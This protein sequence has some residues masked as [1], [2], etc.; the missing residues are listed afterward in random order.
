[1]DDGLGTESAAHGRN[2]GKCSRYGEANR[3]RNITHR[4]LV[5]TRAFTDH[6]S[7]KYAALDWLA[8]WRS[9]G[10]MQPSLA[11]PG[12]RRESSI[13]SWQR[14]GV[15]ATSSVAAPSVDG[16]HVRRPR[17]VLSARRWHASCR[18]CGCG[19]RA[20]GRTGDIHRWLAAVLGDGLSLFGRIDRAWLMAVWFGMSLL[21]VAFSVWWLRYFRFGP[22]EWA[23]RSLVWWRM[24]PLR[25]GT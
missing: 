17:F 4:A 7:S 8:R 1:M 21:Q 19:P 3:E 11:W 14:H 13:A 5:E 12:T 10:S 18:G 15:C 25:R 23:W 9:D 24:Q 2:H 20:A 6:T 22:L 16:T